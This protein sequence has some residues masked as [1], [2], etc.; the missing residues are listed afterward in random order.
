Q[1]RPKGEAHLE[2]RAGLKGVGLANLADEYPHILSG[3]QQQRVALARAIVPRPAVMLMDEP[4]SGLDVQL[5]ES[6]QEETLSL[7]RETRAPSVIVTHHPEE[8]MRI[9][10]RIAVMR[11]GRL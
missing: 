11:A 2:A 6:M 1:S 8:A 9:G 3:G 4:F 10:D 5:R 7:L